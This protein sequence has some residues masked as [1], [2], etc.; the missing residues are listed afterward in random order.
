MGGLISVVF[1]DIGVSKMEKDTVVPLKPLFYKRYVDVTYIRRK[2][3][4]PDN[5]FEKLNSQHKI[6]KLTIVKN[7]T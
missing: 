2:K 5:L 7:L 4:E 6:L 3:N 1:S